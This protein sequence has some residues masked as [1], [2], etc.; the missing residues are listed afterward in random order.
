V[1]E[2]DTD[3]SKRKKI[4]EGARAIFFREGISSLTMD[5]IAARQGISKK[6][7]YKYFTSKQELVEA[8]VEEKIEE[9]AAMVRSVGEDRS[10]PF[11]Q[12]MGM[13]LGI[14]GRQLALLGDRL[15]NDMAYREPQLWERI[16]RFRREKVFGVISALFQEGIR[17]GYVRTDIEARLIPILFITSVTAILSPQQFFALTTPPA[18]VFQTITR[19]LLGGILTD[20]GRAQLALSEPRMEV[21]E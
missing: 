14:V 4:L 19:I 6:T 3:E 15:L 1:A 2:V 7:L 16:D 8:A 12:R 17:D 10:L 5:Q 13:V 21:H 11:P 20:E 9:V 18:V